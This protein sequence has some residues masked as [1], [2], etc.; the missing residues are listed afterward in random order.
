M[1]AK[2]FVIGTVVGLI[3]LYVL[4]VVIF[5]WL[6]DTF[7]MEH[8]GTAVG[9]AREA[10]VWWALAVGMLCY[11]IVINVC[12]D[13]AKGGVTIGKGALVGGVVGLGIWGTTDFTLYAVTNL[14]DLTLTIVD[15]L[16]EFVH[17]GI[18]GAIIGGVVGVMSPKSA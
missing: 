16:L 4:D 17:A 15:P 5:D 7:Y 10:T 12:L 1:N 13:F 14:N 18:S 2:R 3:V 8:G 11:S 9:I 6:F